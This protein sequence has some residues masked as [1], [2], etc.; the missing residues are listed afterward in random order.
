MAHATT[1]SSKR[2]G[3]KTNKPGGLGGPSGRGGRRWARRKA[4][5]RG[6]I[7]LGVRL[8]NKTPREIAEEVKEAAEQ[9]AKGEA[10]GM[11]PYRRAM[12]TLTSYAERAWDS[13]SVERRKQIERA[14]DEIR[15]LFGRSQNTKGAGGPGKRR[16]HKRRR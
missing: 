15:A 14:K 12:T 10:K 13:L 2:K 11:T 9:S 7:D 1:S 5:L 3:A 4:E 8:Q 16:S 6:E